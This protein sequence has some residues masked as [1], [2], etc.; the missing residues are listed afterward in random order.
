[1]RAD[2]LRTGQSP[3]PNPPSCQ[4]TS[5]DLREI[6]VL[7]V[8]QCSRALDLRGGQRGWWEPPSARAGASPT[9]WPRVF[10]CQE[11]QA[12]PSP[13][14]PLAPGML[15]WG[16]A[17]GH[18]EWPTREAVYVAKAA[19]GISALDH[20]SG[21]REIKPS[22]PVCGS[23]TELHSRPRARPQPLPPFPLGALCWPEWQLAGRRRWGPGPPCPQT[24]ETAEYNVCPTRFNPDHRS[25]GKGP[26]KGG[27]TLED[28]LELQV[29]RAG[30]T[31][32]L[33]VPACSVCSEKHPSTAGPAT[34]PSWCRP[35][36]S[37]TEAQL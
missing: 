18:F 5:P 22:R 35:L 10:S 33:P 32:L 17:R 27:T 26:L 7:A 16:Q 4:A 2:R 6:D 12:Y 19:G 24:P 8:T 37:A 3:R 20:R 36:P 13:I 25:L 1:M 11:A 14:A 34:L 23:S 9:A 29:T 30:Q 15:F 31:L 21:A 28:N